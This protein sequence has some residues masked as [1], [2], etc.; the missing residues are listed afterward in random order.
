MKW[1]YSLFLEITL[2]KKT[3]FTV[4]NVI[5]SQVICN[6]KL[7]ETSLNYIRTNCMHFLFY[8]L[9]HSDFFSKKMS[10]VFFQEQSHKSYR[11]LCVLT[12]RWNYLIHQLDPMGYHLLN[13]ILHVGVCV[14]YFR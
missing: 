6:E 5:M 7:K 14:L 11:P 10:T 8:Y 2:K 1:R 12:F 3:S 4:S 9:I 13:V